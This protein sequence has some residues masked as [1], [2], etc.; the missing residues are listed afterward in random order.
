MSWL[1]LTLL[2]ILAFSP[3]SLLYRVLMKDAQSDPY[4]QSIVF[5]GLGGTFALLFSLIHGGFQYQIT[6]NQLFLFLPLTICATVGPVLLFKA[7]QRIEASEISILQSSQK[8]WAVLG[9]FLLLQ[10]PFSVNKILG[11]FIIVLGIAITLWRRTKFQVNEGVAF[12]LIATLFYAGM[13]LVSYYIIRD[14]DAISFIVYVCY[15]PVIT[16]LLLRP[17]TIKKIPYYFKPKY[18]IGVSVLALC[19]T[20]GTLCFFFAYQAGRN[21]AQIVPLAGLITI[22]S[23]LLGIVFL[24]EHSNIPNKVIGSL[25]TV[26]GAVLVL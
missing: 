12:V 7:F 17:Q 3:K 24:R 16:L 2:G 6:S 21:A 19:D 8:F 22:N 15:L 5:F 13:D 26:I 18:A 1:V 20:V 4:A 23:T 25:V 9:A 11:T 10:E 14:F